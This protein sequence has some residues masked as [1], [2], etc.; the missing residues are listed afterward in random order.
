[1][2]SGR[3]AHS[4]PLS[5]L[6]RKKKKRGRDDETSGY[7]SYSEV[8]EVAKSSENT[9]STSLKSNKNSSSDLK[10]DERY[11]RFPRNKSTD[12]FEKK[13]L[14]TTE[15]HKRSESKL[16]MCSEQSGT[17]SKEREKTLK[18]NKETTS[19]SDNYYSDGKHTPTIGNVAVTVTNNVNYDP[20]DPFSFIQPV[21]L[22]F[23]VKL[24]KTL[25]PVSIVLLLLILASA[26]GAAIYFASALKGN[27]LCFDRTLF[28]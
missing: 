12:N 10:K 13:H 8:S 7:N 25:G 26:L 27:V 2:R 24:R 18:K 28:Y 14:K 6:D 23:H 11:S 17:S 4:G 19:F 15:K 16:S 20:N 3:N 9:K 22:P 21:N 5:D 1:M